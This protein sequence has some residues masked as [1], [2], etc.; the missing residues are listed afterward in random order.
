MSRSILGKAIDERA[1]LDKSPLTTGFMAGLRAALVGA[2]LGAAIQAVQG[3]DVLTGAML[4]AVI[5]GLIA[6][7]AK[8]STQKVENLANEAELR[9][10]AGNIKSREPMFFMP[11]RQQLG[12]YFSRRYD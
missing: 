4:G 1:V 7:M 11:P 3:K 6:G 9:Y 10:Y 2:P 8:G 5:P 12:K